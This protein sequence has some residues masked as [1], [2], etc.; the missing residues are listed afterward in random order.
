[1]CWTIPL[2]LLPSMRFAFSP[3]ACDIRQATLLLATWGWRLVRVLFGPHATNA[4]R[5]KQLLDH[6][7]LAQGQDSSDVSAC[8]RAEQSVGVVEPPDQMRGSGWRCLPRGQPRRRLSVTELIVR[9]VCEG[10]SCEASTAAVWP[11]RL[12]AAEEQRG[13]LRVEERAHRRVGEP[14]AAAQ[15]PREAQAACSGLG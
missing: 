14:L 13:L 7:L 4:G 11:A 5:P 6:A 12:T 9:R 15:I 8:R 3:L 1:M 10:H 2:S